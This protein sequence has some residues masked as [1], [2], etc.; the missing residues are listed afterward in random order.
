MRDYNSGYWHPPS[1][2]RKYLTVIFFCMGIKC[3][4]KEEAKAGPNRGFVKETD[5]LL[6]ATYL[7][8]T[9][10]K[11]YLYTFLKVVFVHSVLFFNM[12]M[13]KID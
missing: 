7:N 2:L 1:L 3:L 10:L 6:I 8:H 4:L 12:T 9:R 13:M 5:C 11:V